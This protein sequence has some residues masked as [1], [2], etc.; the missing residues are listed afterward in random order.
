MRNKC[1]AAAGSCAGHDKFQQHIKD[2]RLVLQFG[3][4]D[5]HSPSASPSQ[6]LCALQPKRES[7]RRPTGARRSGRVDPDLVVAPEPVGTTD[8]N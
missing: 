6:L 8:A 1:A 2:I 5:L 3:H 7:P 4:A